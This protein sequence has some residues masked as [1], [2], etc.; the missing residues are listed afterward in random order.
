MHAQTSGSLLYIPDIAP[1]PDRDELRI[2]T[3]NVVRQTIKHEAHLAEWFRFVRATNLGRKNLKTYADAYL[4]Q[5]YVRVLYS[6]HRQSL[7]RQKTKV[8]A[9]IGLSLGLSSD[10]L[11]LTK[12]LV[13]KRLGKDWVETA[14]RSA[15][16][17]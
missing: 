17:H 4:V 15:S 2:L 7:A 3:E 14:L 5:H 12:E 1:L 6:R 9:T 13:Q 16:H 8:L 11:R 10:H